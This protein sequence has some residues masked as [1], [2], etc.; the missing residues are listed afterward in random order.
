MR[1]GILVEERVEVGPEPLG[2]E[3][4]RACKRRG[5]IGIRV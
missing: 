5:A 1:R 2:V 3:N 4:R